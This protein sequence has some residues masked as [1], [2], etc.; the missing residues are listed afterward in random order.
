MQY[1]NSCYGQHK[2][3]RS[4][5]KRTFLPPCSTDRRGNQ[6]NTVSSQVVSSTEDNDV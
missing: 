6:H 1:L 5:L 3:E 4:L 2:I